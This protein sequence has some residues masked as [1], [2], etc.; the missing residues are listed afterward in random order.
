MFPFPRLKAPV[1]CGA[2]QRIGRSLRACENCAIKHLDLSHNS[3]K[4][5]GGKLV[6]NSVTF[7]GYCVTLVGHSVEIQIRDLIFGSEVV[8][9]LAFEP[10]GSMG[11]LEKGSLADLVIVD[12][13]PLEDIT[14]L[15]DHQKLTVMKDGVLYQNLE[16]PNP[17]LAN[18]SG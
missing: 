6:G 17:Y 8:C 5:A 3:I 4:D 16:N 2:E 13:N 14:I 7:V 11:T 12:G 9:S 1:N 10:D 15:Q 18:I